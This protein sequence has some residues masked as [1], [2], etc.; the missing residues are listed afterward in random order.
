MDNLFDQVS[1]NELKKYYLQ[2]KAWEK[3]GIVSGSEL[4][5]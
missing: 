1:D 4:E 2:F 3:T 5:K